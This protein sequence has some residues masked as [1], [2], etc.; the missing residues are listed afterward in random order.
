LTENDFIKEMIDQVELRRV[1]PFRPV[2]V[3]VKRVICH[4]KCSF[5][6]IREFYRKIVSDEPDN[7]DTSSRT[8][9]Q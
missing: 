3:T 5:P 9:H 6:H 1:V 8:Y 2:H 4:V 7:M